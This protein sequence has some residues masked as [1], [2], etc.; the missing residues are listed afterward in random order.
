MASRKGSEIERALLAK[1]FRYDNAHHRYLTL[2]VEGSA[3]AIRTYVS[4]GTRDYGD[5]L[6]A[7]VRKQLHLPRKADL[8]DLIDCPMSGADYITVLRNQGLV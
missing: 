3:T 6:L 8:L 1:G 5:D 7:K 4:H 2:H